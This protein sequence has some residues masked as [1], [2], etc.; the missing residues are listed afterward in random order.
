VQKA[1]RYETYVVQ[2][3]V[4]MHEGP[5]FNDILEVSAI[6]ENDALN[7][8]DKKLSSMLD[9]LQKAGDNM[10]MCFTA[11]LAWKAAT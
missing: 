1:K 7:Q 9:E 11:Q 3:E 8:A 6:D 4:E 2:Y 10:I 5:S